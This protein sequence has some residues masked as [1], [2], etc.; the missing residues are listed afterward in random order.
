MPNAVDCLTISD[1]LGFKLRWVIS[2]EGEMSQDGPPAGLAAET[3]RLKD[4]LIALQD[5]LNEARKEIIALTK[6]LAE[7]RGVPGRDKGGVEAPA[8]RN[9]SGQ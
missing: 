4:R 1:K 6:E 5:E 3:G 2:G 7:A 9:A 8:R